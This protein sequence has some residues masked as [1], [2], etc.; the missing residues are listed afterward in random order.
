[1]NND[2]LHGIDMKYSAALDLGKKV[3]E[4]TKYQA[5]DVDVDKLA[6]NISLIE[7]GGITKLN[8]R[9]IDGGR[10]IWDTFSEHNFAAALISHH[11]YEIPIIYEP[12]ELHRPPDFKIVIDRLTYWVQIKKLS[13]LRRENEQNRIVQTIKRKTQEINITKFFAIYLSDNFSENDIPGLIDFIAEHA[14]HSMEGE[15]YLFIGRN[16]SKA[17][18]DFWSPNKS[19]I[20][21]LTLGISGDIEIVNETGL[22]KNQI[23]QSIINAAGAFEWNFDQHTINLV[24][25]DSDKQI[26]I[27]LCDA[28]FG[29]ECETVIDDKLYWGRENDGFFNMPAFFNKISGVIAM[30]RKEAKPVSNYFFMLFLNDNFK[31]RL[32]DL[33][34]LLAF[35][36]VIYENMRPPMGRGNFDLA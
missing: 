17:K 5:S 6:R 19:I 11:N 8:N 1:M 23:K 32:S 24:A 26:D 13:N 15:Q 10:N 4:Q 3:F 2:L 33:N 25:M 20:S 28:I 34:K 36:K 14:G 30:R 29:T 27:D 22:A 21:S 7:K 12:D 16:K 9:L 18:L 31:D 35:D